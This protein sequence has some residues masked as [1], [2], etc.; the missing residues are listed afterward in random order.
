[1]KKR[2]FGL[3]LAVM[4][5]LVVFPTFAD[6]GT[7]AK[8]AYYNGTYMTSVRG[9]SSQKKVSN[10]VRQEPNTMDVNISTLIWN[11]QSNFIFRGYLAG[12]STTC[13]Y[14]KQIVGTGYRAATYTIGGSM[15]VDLYMS[16]ASSST[17]D[18]LY[19]IGTYAI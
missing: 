8:N 14:A 19:F 9:G 2:V 1:M 5:L 11:N 16:I 12:T 17:S 10:S 4:L 7:F 6:S 3:I 13:T 15:N 18:K